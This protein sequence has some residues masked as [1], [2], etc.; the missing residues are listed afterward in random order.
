MNKNIEEIKKKTASIF[1]NH[2]VKKAAV[3]GS[4]ARG[5]EKKGSDIDI[6]IEFKN[7]NKSLLELVDLKLELEEV[8][9]RKIDVVEYPTIKPILKKNILKDQLPIL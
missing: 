4:F 6:L 5:E 8:L 2:G 1:K 9:K 7:D 3:F